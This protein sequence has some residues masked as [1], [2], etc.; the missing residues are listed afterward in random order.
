MLLEKPFRRHGGP[1]IDIQV[2][3]QGMAVPS[4]SRQL[5]IC[6]SGSGASA[7]H[8][9]ESERPKIDQIDRHILS[10][11]SGKRNQPLG[12][13]RLMSS[14]TNS[15]REAF[16]NLS[17]N[18]ALRERHSERLDVRDAGTPGKVVASFA[19][20]TRQELN[21]AI[22]RAK[23]PRTTSTTDTPE[24]IRGT[25]RALHLDQDWLEVTAAYYLFKGPQDSNRPV[26]A[27]DDVV[28]PMVNRLVNVSVV[29]RGR[30][31]Y[32][33]R[34]R[35]RGI[36]V[37]TEN[38]VLAASIGVVAEWRSCR[39]DVEGGRYKRLRPSAT[40]P[41]TQDSSPAAV[42]ELPQNLGSSTACRMECPRPRQMHLHR[43]ARSPT[44]CAR[45]A[46]ICRETPP[47]AH[48]RHPQFL[49]NLAGLTR[50]LICGFSF[51]SEAAHHLPQ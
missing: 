32:L 28:G 6:G 1:A 29:R 26:E 17:R 3:V 25:L 50:L 10:S 9:W 11:P 14:R 2:D 47:S 48:L 39:H 45:V 24:T 18:L 23:P 42:A 44:G 21:A 5:P 27:L 35:A 13:S 19:A 51:D 20:E 38:S 33:S 15:T 4:A 16:L 22:R 46:L 34:Y 43:A 37:P 40:S 7:E 49:R 30:E 41:H 8:S 31:G 36:T 12:R